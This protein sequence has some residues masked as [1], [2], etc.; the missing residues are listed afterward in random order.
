[1][2]AVSCPHPALNTF[3]VGSQW[4]KMTYRPTGVPWESRVK[5]NASTRRCSMTIRKSS[6]PSLSMS[7]MDVAQGHA[8]A[9]LDAPHGENV[10]GKPQTGL[11]TSAC[12]APVGRPGARE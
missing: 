5:P 8:H 2:A 6:A 4:A 10:V 9:G 3:V 12:S 1:M 11:W 7:P